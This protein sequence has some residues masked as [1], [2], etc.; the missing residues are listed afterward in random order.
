MVCLAPSQSPILA[1][2][3]LTL[4][5]NPLVSTKMWRLR[6]LTFLPHQSHIRTLFRRFDRL[7]VHTSG[8][9]RCFSPFFI[10]AMWTCPDSVEGKCEKMKFSLFTLRTIGSRPLERAA[11]LLENFEE[12]WNKIAGDRIA[13]QELL[14]LIV[15]RVW[16]RGDNVEMISLRPNFHVGFESEK[17]TEIQV[18]L[19]EGIT[20]HNRER[21]D[22][23]PRSLA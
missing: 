13:Q 3:T 5:S 23:N 14:Q 2:V 12:H 4:S 20:I 18:D 1:A 19:E 6:P 16:V 11:D 17:P 9:G 15:A 10:G 8:T 22:L 21:R 7:T